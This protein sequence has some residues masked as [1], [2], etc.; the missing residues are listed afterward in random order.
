[1][2]HI[3]RIWSGSC[4]ASRAEEYL[5]YL[6]KTGVAD[7]TSTPGNLGVLVLKRIQNDVADFTFISFWKSLEAITQFAG[8]DIQRAVYYPEDKDFLLKLDPEVQHFEVAIS[9]RL[10]LFGE[11]EVNQK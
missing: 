2:T 6:D 9:K 4:E 5:E 8:P 11:V 3:A 1:M 10:H 7:T